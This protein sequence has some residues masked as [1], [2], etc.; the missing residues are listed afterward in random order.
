MLPEP[1]RARKLTSTA[2]AMVALGIAPPPS[3][4]YAQPQF[5][6]RIEER[7][8]SFSG[9]V[10]LHAKNLDS[11]KEFS[12]QP[13]RRVRTAS[14]IKLPIMAATFS[15]VQQGKAQ[16]NDTL[17]MRAN[18]K[19]GGTGVIR[20]LTDGTKLTLRDLMH[21]MIVVSDNTATNL[22]IGR[23][24]ADLINAELDKLGLKQTRTLRKIIGPRGAEGHSREGK[25]PE[26]Q[27]FGLGVSTPR[28]MVALIEKLEGGA[29]VSADAS[30]EMLAILER[31][32]FKDGI[33]R[34]RAAETASKSGSLDVLRSDVGL[35]RSKGG[36]IAIA[37]TVDDMPRVDYSPDNVG[38]LLIADLADMIVEGLSVPVA[39]ITSEQKP[40]RIVELSATIDHVQ[41]IEVDGERLWLSWV[42]RKARTGH[43]SLFD[44]GSGK[45]IRTAEVQEGERY[46][47]GGIAAD[48]TSIWVPVAEYKPE[49]SAS[50]Q[51]RNRE[52]LALESQ[53]EVQDHIGCVAIV[54]DVLYGGNWDSRT[55]YQWTKDGRQLGVKPNTA[56]TSYQDMKATSTSLIGSGLRGAVPGSVDWLDPTTNTLQKRLVVGKTS[57]GVVLTHEGMAIANGRIYFVP[58]DGPSRV[59]VYS[60]PW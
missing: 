36:R 55:M 13:D 50:I 17:E 53:F 31:Q 21:I 25:L 41:G 15:A 46:H 26:L 7:I 40:E 4:L 19:V 54:G 47:P 32:Q 8:R 16:W 11:G 38:N 44:L 37:I 14:T 12:V 48:A 9:T 56:R 2:I 59:F 57:R 43:L 23:I 20:E 45:L 39:E 27:K 5:H 28:E 30:R 58:E 22:I 3:A 52:T 6:T 33:G 35:V 24:T 34:R 51:R 10:S 60:L 18:D 42:D 29:V 49:S 1:L